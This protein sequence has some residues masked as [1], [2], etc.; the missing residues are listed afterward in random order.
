MAAAGPVADG[1]VLFTNNNW[2]MD[3][4]ELERDFEGAKVFLLND[5]EA[6]AYALPILQKN[7]CLRI[8]PMPRNRTWNRAWDCWPLPEKR[9]IVPDCG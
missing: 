6:A 8:G 4:G 1:H 9:A 3:E 7:D 2:S 5:F